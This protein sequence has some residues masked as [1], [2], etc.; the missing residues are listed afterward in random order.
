MDGGPEAS[1][2]EGATAENT[3]LSPRTA[4][5]AAVAVNLGVSFDEAV[6]LISAGA[7]DA[8][9]AWPESSGAPGPNSTEVASTARSGSDV[10]VAK[11]GAV[12]VSNAARATDLQRCTGRYVRTPHA[13]NEWHSG[14]VFADA[15]TGLK[16]A[17]DAGVEWTLRLDTSHTAFECGESN[18]YRATQPR[19]TDLVWD[20]WSHRLSAFTFGPDTFVRVPEDCDLAAEPSADALATNVQTLER[21]T[22]EVAGALAQ[23]GSTSSNSTPPMPA[24]SH[25]AL[26]PSWR[27]IDMSELDERRRVQL[28]RQ[29]R[30]EAWVTEE[31][32]PPEEVRAYSSVWENNALGHGHARSMLDSPQGW[33]ADKNQSNHWLQVDL[34]VQREVVGFWIQGRANA[35]QWVTELTL[36]TSLDG[37][38]FSTTPTSSEN[39]EVLDGSEGKNNKARRWL[40]DAVPARFVRFLPTAWHGHPSAR[41]AVLCLPSAKAESQMGDPAIAL[42]TSDE[43]QAARNRMV[44]AAVKELQVASDAVESATVRFDTARA[45]LATSEESSG[46]VFPVHSDDFI[47]AAVAL[48]EAGSKH[49]KAKLHL[50]STH[51]LMGQ[52]YRVG[53]GPHGPPVHTTAPIYTVD[54][55]TDPCQAAATHTQKVTWS[56]FFPFLFAAALNA[57]GI[58]VLTVEELSAWEKVFEKSAAAW[59]VLVTRVVEANVGTP[60]LTLSYWLEH[61][62]GGTARF[63]PDGE[64]QSRLVLDRVNEAVRTD[65]MIMVNAAAA[66]LVQAGW[67]G[68]V[69]DDCKTASAAK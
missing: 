1:P 59:S 14:R 6:A 29:R 11:D 12:K 31:V 2:A 16:W 24:L 52:G 62:K 61:S 42:Y 44:A 15:A 36:Q 69:R 33:S 60:E 65:H 21:H 27:V 20:S 55:C 49:A 46:C 4:E 22:D 56:C 26:P 54:N 48:G 28:L 63:H 30:W 5:A 58:P 39:A 9:Q 23:L 51:L 35:D 53:Q 66:E 17:N 45:G 47:N 25:A 7:M 34:G 68:G 8:W 18:P 32:N 50:R 43:A 37:D 19:F 64:T 67:V 3:P 57:V 13:E 10:A 40:Q 38:H 41:V